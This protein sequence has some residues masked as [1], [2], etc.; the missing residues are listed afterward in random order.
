ML[1]T[2]IRKSLSDRGKQ[3]FARLIPGF[4]LRDYIAVPGFEI[5]ESLRQKSSVFVYP[6]EASTPSETARISIACFQSSSGS[7]LPC[8]KADIILSPDRQ[9]RCVVSSRY[10][11]ELRKCRQLTVLRKIHTQP[12]KQPVHQLCLRRAAHAGDGKPDIHRRALPFVE[13]IGSRNICPSVM[14][15]TFV[16]I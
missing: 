1:R 11:A 8:R 10:R 2:K 3:L 9:T 6:A 14:E 5:P 15:I 13:K 16:G 7:Y 12:R 4:K